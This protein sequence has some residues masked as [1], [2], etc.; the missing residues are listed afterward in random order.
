MRTLH[1]P[2]PV[3]LV[4]LL[5]GCDPVAPTDPGRS[6]VSAPALAA[7]AA[8]SPCTLALHAILR[9]P[10]S[11]AVVGRIQFRIDPPEPGSSDAIARY[12][13]VYG[14]TDG[15][16]FGVLTVGLLSRVPD[17][18]PTWTDSDKTDPGATLTSV[19]HFA[20]IAPMS[21]V[22]ALALVD[23][24]SR[25][26]AIVNVE[27]T[28]GGSEAE[29]LVDPSSNVPESLRERRRLCFGGG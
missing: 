17:Q 28:T 20:D 22:M 2:F 25:F 11:R 27:G 7:K 21:Q 5:A 15:Q 26:K 29:G 18:G 6:T 3:V 12:R 8:D 24:A 16:A 19:V 1:F 10:G 14:P 4:L 9:E 23:D 13:G